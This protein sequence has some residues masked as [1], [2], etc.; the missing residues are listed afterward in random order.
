MGAF[1][2]DN[3][4]NINLNM[5][6]MRDNFNRQVNKHGYLVDAGGNIIN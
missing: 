1:D 5:E 4:G 3:F 6:L 2:I